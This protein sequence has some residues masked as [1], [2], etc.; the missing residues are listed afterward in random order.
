MAATTASPVVPGKADDS[1]LIRQVEGRAKPKMPPKTD[2][3]PEEIAIAARVDRSR[4]EVLAGAARRRSTRRCR[5]SRR[6]RSLLAEVPSLAFSPDGAGTRRRRLQRG[7]AV[8]RCRPGE[9]SRAS[10]GLA[11]QVR[12]VAWS[13][14]GKLIAAGGG[15]PG[16]FGELVLIDAAT[17]TVVRTLD[18]HRDYVYHVAF[19]PDG[20]RL[21]SCGY[22]KLD[23]D[24]GHG[25][26]QADGRAEGA[27]RS[28][29]RRRVRRDGDA[30]RVGGRRSIGEDLGRGERR[31]AVHDHR[32]DRCRA[33]AGVSARHERCWSPAAPTSACASGRSSDTSATLIGNTLAHTGGD[34]P[35]G[36]LARW[37]PPGDSVDGPRR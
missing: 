9:R 27:H 24:L 36:V 19:S 37:H 32:S 11:D 28:G 20:K 33:D 10:D 29:V 5:R 34:H 35:G 14:D 13:P 31:P 22:D 6:P 17:G 3:R 4:R 8:L 23:S 2:L 7:P 15:T 25:H 16:A 30:A 12:A 1:P 18:G 26:R 21:A